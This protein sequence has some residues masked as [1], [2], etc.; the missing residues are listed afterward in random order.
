MKEILG[1]NL[2]EFFNKQFLDRSNEYK[3]TY[4]GSTYQVWEVSDELLSEMVQISCQTTDNEWLEKWFNVWWRYAE[5]SVLGP[6]DAF[7]TIGKYTIYGWK[8]SS[9]HDGSFFVKE[10]SDIFEYLCEYI[11]ASQPRNVCACLVD[12]A[13]YNNMTMGQLLTLVGNGE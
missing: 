9:D 11:G 6:C 7:V 10:Y 2:D 13:K 4:V 8:K 5:G 1:G 12:L 3:K